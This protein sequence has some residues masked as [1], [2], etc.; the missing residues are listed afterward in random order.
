MLRF[1]VTDR[2]VRTAFRRLE[3]AAGPGGLDAG[4]RAVARAVRTRVGLGFR[5][6]ESPYG[7]KWAPPKGRTGQPLRKSGRLQRSIRSRVQGRRAV[8]GTNLRYARTHQFGARIRAKHHPVLRFQVGG[9][10]VSKKEVRI[11]ARPFLPT[12][13]LPESWARKVVDVLSRHLQR[14]IKGG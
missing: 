12:E 9:R 5:R 8:I 1:N 4:L 10:W 7:R 2:G 3:R 6:G 13:G 14:A 11:P